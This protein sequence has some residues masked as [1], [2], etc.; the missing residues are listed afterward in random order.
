[1]SSKARPDL[2]DMELRALRRA[3]ARR[4][5]PELFLHERAFDDCLERILLHDRRFERALLI[6]AADATWITRLGEVAQWTD[7][8]DEAVAEDGWQPPPGAYDLIVAIGTLDS[9]NDLPAALRA[10]RQA[11]RP[12]GLFIGAMS[13]GNTLPQLRAAMRAADA[14]GGAA[15]A[16]VH[17]R[18]EPAALAP[19][20]EQAGFVQPVVDVDRVQVSYPSLAR[21]VGDLRRLAATNLLSARPRFVGRAARAAAE[22]AFAQAGDGKR[23]VE[24][25]EILHF[26]SWTPHG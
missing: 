19:L 5:G 13:G 18:I 16:H 6:G 21:L 20:L 11:M 4:L 9:V 25:F 23:T 8:Y 22:R 24:V 2:F 1:M 7:L 17:P 3:R 15:F 10:I 12:G 14:V 26:A